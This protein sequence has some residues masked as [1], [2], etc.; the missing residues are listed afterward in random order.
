MGN[1]STKLAEKC[2]ILSKNEIPV[3]ASSFKVRRANDLTI[4]SIALL[5]LSFFTYRTAGQQKLGANQR[6]RTE[7]VL[8]HA[9]GSASVSIHNEFPVRPVG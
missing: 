1:S 5:M 3:V 9:N 7:K 4:F 2:S 8:G 6:G